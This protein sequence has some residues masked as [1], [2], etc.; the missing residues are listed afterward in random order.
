[1]PETKHIRPRDPAF[2]AYRPASNRMWQVTFPGNRE[3]RYTDKELTELF[4]TTEGTDIEP[5]EPV[6]PRRP[7]FDLTIETTPSTDV[8]PNRNTGFNQAAGAIARAEKARLKE[9]TRLAAVSWKN[10]PGAPQPRALRKWLYPKNSIVTVTVFWE[11]NPTAKYPNGVYRKNVDGHDTLPAMC[12]GIVDGL[13]EAGILQDDSEIDATYN[14]EKDPAG[15]GYVRIT[16]EEP[17]P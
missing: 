12:K 17:T 10:A 15:R 4:E 16:V 6:V 11:K 2:E 1:M 7:K 3:G 14:Q 8:R 9:M 5:S 13:T